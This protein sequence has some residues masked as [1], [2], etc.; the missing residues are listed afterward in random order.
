MRLV[1]LGPPG[2]GKGTQA[3]FLTARLGIPKIS[4]GDML[5]EAAAAE[6]E[7]GLRG[8]HYTD[9]GLLVPDE[10][11][12]A[13]VENRLTEPDTRAGYLLDGFP[14]TVPQAEAL[15][16]WLEER[17]RALDG[18]VNIEVSDDEIVDRISSRRVCPRC[19]ETYH[20]VTCPPRRDD[21][22]NSCGARLALRNDDRPEVVRERLRVYHQRT[23][24]LIDYYRRKGRLVL[25]D[26]ME[27]VEAVTE[28]IVAALRQGKERDR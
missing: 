16:G 27:P 4:T 2:A 9:Q 22:C 21:A 12:L 19:H 10:M 25:I 26:G 23:E 28:A 20:L 14:R 3:H 5:R 8:K 6:S 15:G 18:A 11:I 24:P 1:L 17:G 7:L 13:L